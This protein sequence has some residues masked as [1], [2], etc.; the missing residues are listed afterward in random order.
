[1]YRIEVIWPLIPL[2]AL[3]LL[4]TPWFGAMLAVFAVLIVAATVLV[5]LVG[6]IV[7]LPVVLALVARRHWRSGR[8]LPTA[9]ALPPAA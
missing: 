2:G 4:V 8:A 6:S 1:M 9:T 5:T 3:T 7:A